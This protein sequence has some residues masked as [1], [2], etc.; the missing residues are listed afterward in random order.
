MTKTVR[1]VKDMF[2]ACR[3]ES[4]PSICV[5]MRLAANYPILFQDWFA[6]DPN[7]EYELPTIGGR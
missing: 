3:E 4:N 7:A 1:N 6:Y 2:S 5:I